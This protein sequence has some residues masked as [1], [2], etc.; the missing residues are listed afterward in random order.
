MRAVA[1]AVGCDQQVVRTVWL[2]RPTDACQEAGERGVVLHWN[3]REDPL[4]ELRVVGLGSHLC[5]ALQLGDAHSSQGYVVILRQHRAAALGSAH[6]LPRIRRRA[7]PR[8]P[9]Q[10][11]TYGGNVARELQERDGELQEPLERRR[12]SRGRG[13]CGQWAS[14]ARVIT[15]VSPCAARSRTEARSAGPSLQ[16]AAGR[17]FIPCL[18]V[19]R[20]SLLVARSE[21]L[22][23]A[24]VNPKEWSRYAS[25]WSPVRVTWCFPLWEW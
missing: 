10:Q 15:M 25:R 23:N 11:F 3:Q 5:T 19:A 22:R 18:L 13:G 20:C 17:R 24:S 6:Q 1:A 16:S 21:L 14:P 4:D 7:P 2:P 8:S 9:R 12:S